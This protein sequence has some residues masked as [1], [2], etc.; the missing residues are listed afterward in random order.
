MM[1]HPMTLGRNMQSAGFSSHRSRHMERSVALSRFAAVVL[2]MVSQSGMAQSVAGET[3]S[4]WT[5]RNPPAAPNG[6]GVE[7]LSTGV[8]VMVPRSP[9]AL[10]VSD[11]NNAYLGPELCRP[12]WFNES[13]TPGERRHLRYW[14]FPTAGSGLIL[15]P[16]LN[17]SGS[18]PSSGNATLLF[19]GTALGPQ[20]ARNLANL[21]SGMGDQQ[22]FGYGRWDEWHLLTL[23]VSISDAGFVGASYRVE[24]E[25]G[26]ERL[27]TASQ[28]VP[29]SGSSYFLNAHIAHAEGPPFRSLAEYTL[30]DVFLLSS[31][32]V[33]ATRLLLSPG[34]NGTCRQVDVGVAVGTAPAAFIDWR[35]ALRRILGPGNQVTVSAD[36]GVVMYVSPG[37]TGPG[38]TSLSLVADGG[39]R[40]VP[41]WVAA[42]DGGAQSAA[43]YALS[44]S[45]LPAR[46][47]AI[48]VE[49]LDAGTLSPSGDGGLDG[50]RA[51]SG[52]DAGGSSSEPD[53]GAVDSGS[54]EADAGSGDAGSGDGGSRDAG[55][56]ANRDGGGESL[57][58]LPLWGC[59]SLGVRSVLAIGTLLGLCRRRRSASSP[60]RS[61]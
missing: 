48:A 41:I 32:D 50:G 36:G 5:V 19:E 11:T 55:S 38:A 30:D 10:R 21:A 33:P 58:E 56:F 1:F 39:V 12:T 60:S 52:T 47:V 43:L 40:F 24:N 15:L 44:P 45:Y 16:F 57:K 17:L 6:C 37:C 9:P 2:V 20:F 14:L 42:L 28:L 49:A 29:L 23:S 27:S 18:Q 31:R 61:R 54:T 8:G 51:D 53:A 35:D 59:Q 34:A 13:L 25:S 4:N 3:F 22:T 7:S 26:D 46:P